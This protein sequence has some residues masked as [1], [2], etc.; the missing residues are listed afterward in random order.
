MLTDNILID[1]LIIYL[2]CLYFILFNN[3]KINR[4]LFIVLPLIIY[5]FLVFFKLRAN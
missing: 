1:S 5:T 3:M 4:S 2:F